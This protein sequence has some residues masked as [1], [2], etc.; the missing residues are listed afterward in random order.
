MIRKIGILGGTFDPIHI[1]HLLIAKQCQDL[2]GLEKIIFVPCFISPLKRNKPMLDAATR[3]KLVKM[4]VQ[5]NKAYEV[6][7]WEVKQGKVSYTIDTLKFLKQ[8]YPVNTRFYFISGSDVLKH[9]EKWRK[10]DELFKL[11]QFIVVKRPCFSTK[12]PKGAVLVETNITDISSTQIKQRLKQGKSIRYM[13]PDSI[14]SCLI[15]Y[16]QNKKI[17]VF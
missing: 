14:L 7:D 13:V 2:L 16:F 8:K 17:K 12:V 10:V 4:A 1:G 11:C 5:D 3:L 6:L 15:K 9:L